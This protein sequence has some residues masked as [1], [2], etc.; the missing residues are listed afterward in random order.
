MEDV[1]QKLGDESEIGKIAVDI[2]QKQTRFR[3]KKP[4]FSILIDTSNSYV[5]WLL[6]AIVR[7]WRNWQTRQI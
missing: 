3:K 1:G 7:I 6:N 2:T 5:L 4:G